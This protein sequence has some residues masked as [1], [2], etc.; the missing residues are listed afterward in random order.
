[1]PLYMRH[2]ATKLKTIAEIDPTTASNT[3][4]IIS[5][6]TRMIKPNAADNYPSHKTIIILAA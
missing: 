2:Q 1:M 5:Q 4:Y 6:L 3:S